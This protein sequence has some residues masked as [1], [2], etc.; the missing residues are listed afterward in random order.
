ML[1][2][3]KPAS[4]TNIEDDCGTHWASLLHRQTF[5]GVWAQPPVE[6]KSTIEEAQSAESETGFGMAMEMELPFQCGNQGAQLASLI[7]PIGWKLGSK[8]NQIDVALYAQCWGYRPDETWSLPS[9]NS[10][11]GDRYEKS[12][13]QYSEVNFTRLM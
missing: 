13:V 1:V 10:V 11:M 4:N 8:M 2:C 5:Q 3:K 9:W 6:R 7:Q 12:P